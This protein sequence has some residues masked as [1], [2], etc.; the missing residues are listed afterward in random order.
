MLRA[1]EAHQVPCSSLCTATRP[2]HIAYKQ[3]AALA[4]SCLRTTSAYDC[5]CASHLPRNWAL[6]GSALP[7]ADTLQLERLELL[8]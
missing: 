4:G 7:T 6:L 1:P 8:A 5:L 2:L 3:K